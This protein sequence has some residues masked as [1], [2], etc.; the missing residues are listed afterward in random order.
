MNIS[1][2]CPFRFPLV[3]GK[4]DEMWLITDIKRDLLCWSRTAQ[5]SWA[6]AAG[7]LVSACDFQ[8]TCCTAV[9]NVCCPFQDT[10]SHV[11]DELCCCWW[12]NV[13]LS[14]SRHILSCWWWTVCAD[15]SLDLTVTQKRNDMY[16]K[17]R[18][19]IS[20]V[21]A[22]HVALGVSPHCSG[23]VLRWMSGTGWHVVN[24]GGSF[25]FHSY[26]IVMP[27]CCSDLYLFQ[28]T[29]QTF[30]LVLGSEQGRTHGGV[31]QRVPPCGEIRRLQ[32]RCGWEHPWLRSG[33]P[34]L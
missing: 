19:L 10:F 25:S 23:I 31:I 16:D 24:L 21:L 9:T 14:L 17:S 6:T 30:T 2:Y 22:L 12:M 28:E 1:C 4:D 3:K 8:Q 33:N 18:I 32:I 20:H 5:H 34:C 29:S 15:S 13:V 27:G 26:I 11:A 7:W